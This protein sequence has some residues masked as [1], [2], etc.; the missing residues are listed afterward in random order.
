MPHAG[1][2]VLALAE[3][4]DFVL[5]FYIV[6]IFGWSLLSML[7]VDRISQVMRLAGTIV[8]PLLRPLR[9]KLVVGKYR[10]FADGGG[11]GGALSAQLMLVAESAPDFPFDAFEGPRAPA[12]FQP[13]ATLKV[14]DQSFASSA[15]AGW[16]SGDMPGA[17]VFGIASTP[18]SLAAINQVAAA[19][20][21]PGAT[22]DW[23]QQSNNFQTPPIIA[24]F[25]LDAAQT[26]TLKRIAS[27]CLPRGR[28]R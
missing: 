11:A 18:G 6:L 23:V 13:S 8:E 17:F 27:P 21:K 20:S 16:Y 22:L 10:F 3:L 7:A 26:S 14:G 28:R 12:S 19:L 25:A 4:L 5:L 2:L 24:H 15:V 1:L 9:G